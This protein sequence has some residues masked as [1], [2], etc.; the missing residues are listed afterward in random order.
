MYLENYVEG[1]ISAEELL[2]F[3]SLPNS[4]YLILAQCIALALSA[5]GL[6]DAGEVPALSASEP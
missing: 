4:D 1:I 6:V 5:I 3:F 2:R